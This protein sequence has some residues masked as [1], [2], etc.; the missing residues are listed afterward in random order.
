MPPVTFSGPLTNVTINLDELL[1]ETIT[2]DPSRISALDS[3]RT[4]PFTGTF[5]AAEINSRLEATRR[6]LRSTWFRR[7]IPPG[8][9]EDH[10]PVRQQV[11]LVNTFDGRL[12]G[13]VPLRERDDLIASLPYEATPVFSITNANFS[14][15][16]TGHNPFSPSTHSLTRHTMP[17]TRKITLP[18]VLGRRYLNG[19]RE[20]VLAERFHDEWSN[21]EVAVMRRPNGSTY[22]L[23][24]CSGSGYHSFPSDPTPDDL[25]SDATDE[26][27]NPLPWP[28][29]RARRDNLE[30]EAN[31]PVLLGMY[32]TT[33]V[34]GLHAKDELIGAVFAAPSANRATIYEKHSGTLQYLTTVTLHSGWSG[35]TFG[36]VRELA[37]NKFA[38]HSYGYP[39]RAEPLPLSD[40]RRLGLIVDRVR[41]SILQALDPLRPDGK[42]FQMTARSTPVRTAY[43]TRKQKFGVLREEIESVVRELRDGTFAS[44]DVESLA[45]MLNEGPARRASEIA[46]YV[47]RVAEDKGEGEVLTQ[48]DCGHWAP[49]DIDHY[50]HDHRDNS[51]CA[52]CLSRDRY[53]WCNDTDDYRLRDDAYYYDDD[54]CW[55]SVDPGSDDDDS[56]YSGHLQSWNASTH[57]LTHDTSFTPSQFGDF[58]MG[59]ELE[60]QADRGSERPARISECHEYFNESDPT[61]PGYA[62][63]KRDGS[64]DDYSGFEIVT[65]ARKLED[66]VKMFRG[67]KPV[68]L[69]S[70][71]NGNCGMHVH[72]DSRAFSA[73]TLGKFLMFFNDN[74]NVD[75]IRDIAGRHPYRDD[76][77]ERYAAALDQKLVAN[78]KMV[79]DRSSNSSR[80]RM[81]NVTNLTEEEQERLDC[82]IVRESKG[83]YSTVEV[84]IFRGTLR[85]SRLL[86]QIEFANAA[87]HFCRT[88]S[89]QDLSGAAFK[90]WLAPKAGVFPN[91][92]RWLRV[93]PVRNKNYGAETVRRETAEEV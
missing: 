44:Y 63:F 1:S 20:T 40:M 67:W 65:A 78:P 2:L 57:Y 80:Y 25:I 11:R 69:T 39:A 83:S 3:F 87:V 60:V 21:N 16:F 47:N 52:G 28:A 77:A 53:V 41:S 32:A 45:E 70:W 49:N 61:L 84:R 79:K 34:P 37:V 18:I 85:K 66:H 62:M 9:A 8:W 27:G 93:S 89:W 33:D 72:I 46:R 36:R 12:T 5:T 71:D 48:L 76:Q 51:F 56:S 24:A 54:E 30:A 68:D 50:H 7:D 10:D 75:F 81:V 15:T 73:L 64:L 14:G 92:A 90:A 19:R 26:H 58:T 6:E 43:R 55:L 29:P 22:L 42:A 91:L 74:K 35:P 82:E 86:A 88:A 23:Y 17:D 13:W 4:S 31:R 59:I 38:P